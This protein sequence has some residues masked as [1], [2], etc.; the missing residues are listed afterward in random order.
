VP[1]TSAASSSSSARDGGR[2]AGAALALA[3]VLVGATP[4]GALDVGVWP[5]F[6]VVTDPAAGTLRWT[7]LG[8]LVAY[9]RTP[10]S[11][12][13][14]VRP[15]LHLRRD[16]AAAD[17]DVVF[18][19]LTAHVE[20]GYEWMRFL[21]FRHSD[22]GA[23]GHDTTL[24]PVFTWRDD[25]EHGRGAAVFP[26][27]ARLPGFLGYDDFATLLF[28][29]WLRV[30]YQGVTRRWFPFPFV[31]TVSGVNAHGLRLW[32]LWGDTD[33]AGRAHTR[34][35]LWPFYIAS[36][37]HDPRYGDEHRL[38]VAPFWASLDGPWRTTRGWGVL[39]RTHTVD[40]LRGYEA[41]GSPWPLV[42]RERRLGDEEWEVERWAPVWGRSDVDGVHSRFWAWPLARALDQDQGDDHYRRRDGLLILW[43][44]EREWNED[45]GHAA[46]LW[47]LFPLLRQ[48][49]SDGRVAGQTPAL[50]DALAP[51]SRGVATQWAPLWSLLSWRTDDAGDDLDWSL[52]W[53]LVSRERGR[54]RGPIH[55]DLD[56]A[57]GG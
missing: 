25:P 42:Y 36:D 51:R 32:P 28:P 13:L 27:W 15:L 53:G 23:S 2:A 39:G 33:L 29:L 17:A 37:V 4:A 19:L 50:V 12:E 7:A 3:C 48:V 45:T 43:R 47:T 26:L 22:R 41:I 6:H 34:F 31:S 56:E 57:R 20:P 5:L 38:V 9:A 18:P 24:F 14:F 10:T 21:L 1:G 49:A 54:L 30:E 46:A 8:P 55:L 44:D 11:R 52:L 35:V 16:G 40:R